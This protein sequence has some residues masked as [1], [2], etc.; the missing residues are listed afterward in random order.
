[1]AAS[2]GI[3]HS[4]GLDLAFL[5]LWYRSAAATP[6]QLLAWEVSCAAG[7]ALKREKKKRK[8]IPL[9]ILLPTLSC[10]P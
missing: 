7:A 5:W 9:P 10:V 6:I 4:R 8:L 3:G 1:M 2:C